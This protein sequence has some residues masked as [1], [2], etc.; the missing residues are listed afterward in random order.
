MAW[1]PNNFI[2]GSLYPVIEKGVKYNTSDK[3]E[4]KHF[5]GRGSVPPGQTVHLLFHN[6]PE[7]TP[8][9]PVAA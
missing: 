9:T 4:L 7:V 3:T 5:L 1:A 2:G 8:Q 6:F